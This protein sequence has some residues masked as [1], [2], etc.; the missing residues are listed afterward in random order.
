MHIQKL[1]CLIYPQWVTEKKLSRNLPKERNVFKKCEVSAR[2]C[3]DHGMTPD[4][5]CSML[6]SWHIHAKNSDFF[7][8]IA[9]FWQLFGSTFYFSN[10][11]TAASS[12]QRVYTYPKCFPV[13]FY[14][15]NYVYL[16]FYSIQQLK[17]HV[18]SNFLFFTS[19]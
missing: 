18:K 3:P 4:H 17:L 5:L 19:V 15:L 6:L 12:L 7:K 14:V 8:Y 13:G 2:K 10:F 11:H 16:E 1:W 9:F